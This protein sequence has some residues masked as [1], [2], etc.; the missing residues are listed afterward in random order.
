ME[1]ELALV[2]LNGFVYPVKTDEVEDLI[3]NFAD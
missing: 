2:I 3:D 1:S